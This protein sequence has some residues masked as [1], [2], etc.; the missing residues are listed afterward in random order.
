MT[1]LDRW[2]YNLAYQFSRPNWER[3][4]IPEP[5][6]K[7]TKVDRVTNRALDLGCG[8]GTYS[9]YL[10]LRGFKVT[11]VDFSGK[12]IQLARQK[13]RNSGMEVDFRIKDVTNLDFIQQ[14]CDVILDV[15]CFHSLSCQ[16]RG[17]Y[18]ENVAHLTHPG[19]VFLLW[20]FNPS[21]HAGL[22]VSPEEM[23]TLFS[24]YM[25]L[26]HAQPEPFNQRLSTW[27]RF[28]RT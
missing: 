12:A 13:A 2:M 8:S 17:L 26:Q 18:A 19:S 20:G 28:V 15:G 4:G 7:L 10:A 9:I 27:Y 5:I 16:Q 24:P 1:V 25:D 3:S 6:Q 22:G 11:G 21:A 23:Q 14:T